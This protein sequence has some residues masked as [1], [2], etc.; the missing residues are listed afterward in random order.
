MNYDFVVFGA[1]GMQG[2]IAS[3]DLLENKYSVLMCGR[4][5]SRIT[6]LLKKYKKSS[7]KFVDVRDETLVVETIKKSGADIVINCVEGDWNLKVLKECIR[8]DVNCIDLGSEIWMTKRQLALNPILKKKNLISITGIGSV[9]GIGNIMLRYAAR[10]FDKISDI[11]VGF[12]WDSNIK[13]FVVPFSIES[14]IEEFTDPA[15]IVSNKHFIKK[16]PLDSIIEDYHRSIGKQKEFFVR[17]PEQFTFF[18]YFKDHGVKNIKF[19]AGFPEHSFRT[20]TTLIDIGMGSKKDILFNN[21]KIKPVKFLT[22]ILKKIEY[23]KGYKEKE[24]LWVKI[25]GVKN[26]KPKK[27]LMECIVPTLKGWEDAGCNIDTG[28]PASI[29]A[30]MIKKGVITE[31][32]SFAPE[33]VVPPEPFFKELRKRKMIVL[34]NGK[35][36]N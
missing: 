21:I 1:T 30:Q 2:K 11:E 20:I 28:M 12:S 19:Y 35:V 26:N 16:M 10:K 27:I 7:F 17:H 15:P 29:L 36:I 22:E 5:K 24:N 4:D 33:G 18:H 9:P 23:P 14:I 6:H 31:K 34:E 25:T 8:A 3:K 32:G 13:K